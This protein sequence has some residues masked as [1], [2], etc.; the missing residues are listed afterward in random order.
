M[1]T[2]R[3]LAKLLDFPL[4]HILTAYWRKLLATRSGCEEVESYMLYKWP[5]F[6]MTGWFLLDGTLWGERV[7]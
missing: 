5:A 4:S 3:G 6:G 2:L 7:G 1:A